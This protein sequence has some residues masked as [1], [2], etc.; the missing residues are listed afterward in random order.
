VKGKKLI[1]N[2]TCSAHKTTTFLTTHTIS[3]VLTSLSQTTSLA[4][5]TSSQSPSSPQSP[6][7][8]LLLHT[9]FKGSQGD[10][11]LKNLEKRLQEAEQINNLGDFPWTS[12]FEDVLEEYRQKMKKLAVEVLVEEV[13]GMVEGQVRGCFGGEGE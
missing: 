6:L 3:E 7:L 10:A 4:Q 1:W 12:K 11:N 2:Q 8:T 13:K 9:Y 5:T